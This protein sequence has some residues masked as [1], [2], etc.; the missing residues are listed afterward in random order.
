MGAAMAVSLCSVRAGG[1]FGGIFV[2]FFLSV[3]FVI[4]IVIVAPGARQVRGGYL[5]VGADGGD[6]ACAA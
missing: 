5:A 3:S 6:A 4:V 2:I 1:G